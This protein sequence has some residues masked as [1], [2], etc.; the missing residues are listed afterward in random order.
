MFC[1][2]GEV[3]FFK[4]I[5]RR[6]RHIKRYRKIVEVL[7]KHGFG[8]LIDV[9]DLYQFVPLSKRIKK[10]DSTTSKDNKAQRA[11]KVLEELGPTFIKLGQI[12]STR[13]DLIPRQYIE[14]FKKLQ[15]QV[16]AMDFEDLIS[17]IKEEFNQPYQELFK[18]ISK[19]PLATAS[20]GQVHHAT[21][22]DGKQVVVKV[23]R[24]GI[25]RTVETDLEIMSNLAQVLEDR[26]FS[27]SMIKPVDIVDNFSNIITKELDYR[28]EGRNALK[29]NKNFKGESKVIIPDIFWKLTTKRVLTM[30]FMEGKKLNRL[31][32]V[33][34][35]KRLAKLIARTFMKQI[36]ID[37][38]FHAD[39]HPGNIILSS[40]DRLALIDFG[41]VG[42]LSAEDKEAVASLFIAIINKKIDKAIEELLDLGMVD[43]DIDLKSFERDFHRIVEQYYGAKLEE[44]DLAA[45]I[46]RLFDLSF[47]YQIKLPVEFILLAKSLV[48]VEGIV[49]EIDPQFN[50]VTV[51]KPFIY[52]ILRQKLDPR[53]ILKDF[54]EGVHD[55][56]QILLELPDELKQ[57][58]STIKGNNL[59]INLNHIGL[60]RLISK[61][62]IITNRLSISLLISSLIIASSL[63][64]LSDKGGDFFGFPIIGLSGYVV[65]AVL[66]I[67]LIISILRS[68]RF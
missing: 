38:F 25:E 47:K 17:K 54:S 49:E 11:R 67:W 10:I 46:N 56:S 40:R 44:V 1:S 29:F 9:M 22:K 42:Q 6:Y 7:I 36:L 2:G 23:Q 58:L 19:T 27:E 31:D 43:H 16:P 4:G 34:K 64:M 35:N 18:E 30:E 39:P 53:R 20:I 21:L 8:Y 37:G 26:I 45:I 51:A 62:D 15:D 57:F 33:A 14:E 5:T 60:S 32:D 28:V 66:G 3:M 48:T 63:M 68:G 55:L 59:K 65:A 12:L 61:L 13:P 24:V 50:I 41:M 52:Q